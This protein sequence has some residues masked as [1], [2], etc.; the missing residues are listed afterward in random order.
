[1]NIKSNEKKENSAIELVIEVSAAEFDAAI[2]KEYNK[3]KK[4]IM[5][6]GLRKGKLPRKMA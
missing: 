1:M 5:V 6:T 4:N 3:Q 2:N